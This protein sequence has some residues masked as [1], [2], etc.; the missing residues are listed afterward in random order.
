[1]R[2]PA[3]L[4][5]EQGEPCH[6]RNPQ[7]FDHGQ[8][9]DVVLARLHASNIENMQRTSTNYPGTASARWFGKRSCVQHVR[10]AR[11]FGKSDHYGTIIE[12]GPEE[13]YC[14]P[15]TAKAEAQK[16]MGGQPPNYAPP[17][18]KAFNKYIGVHEGKFL[19]GGANEWFYISE[20]GGYD[21]VNEG[22][23][24]FWVEAYDPKDLSSPL[25]V[26]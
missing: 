3:A 21:F 15:M 17:A 13:P 23:L 20:K 12:V 5:S 11:D 2:N 8:R 9:Y 18:D 26:A 6:V 16:Q 25:D 24:P 10:L 22:G 14:S 19:H 4:C 1:R 7:G